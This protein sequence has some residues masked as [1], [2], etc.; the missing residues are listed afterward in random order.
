ME[1]KRIERF[2]D[3]GMHWISGKLEGNT[4]ESDLK[5]RFFSNHLVL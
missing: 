1:L 5:C 3:G 2:R 4:L